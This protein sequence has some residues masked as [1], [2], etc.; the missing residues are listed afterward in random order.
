VTFMQWRALRTGE[1]YYAPLKWRGASARVETRECC[2]LPLCRVSRDEKTMGSRRGRSHD[3]Q[4][5]PAGTCLLLQKE[6]VERP[7]L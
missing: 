6:D 4:T 1:S 3:L 2:P 7:E 5:T